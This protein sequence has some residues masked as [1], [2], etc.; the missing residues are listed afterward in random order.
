VTVRDGEAHIR[1]IEQA[2]RRDDIHA[3][4]VGHATSSPTG[5]DDVPTGWA[6]AIVGGRPRRGAVAGFSPRIAAVRFVERLALDPGDAVRLRLGI[7]PLP[8]GTPGAEVTVLARV[9]HVLDA[10]AAS[11]LVAFTLPDVEAGA[12]RDED[13]V[14]YDE[15]VSLVVAD[16]R[17]V[18]EAHQRA[19]S[20][21]LSV[22]GMSLVTDRA[23]P[24]GASVLVRVGLP[25][26]RHPIQLKA[27]VRWCRPG[28]D[29]R[30]PGVTI[31]LVWSAPDADQQHR[32]AAAVVQ[33][34]RDRRHDPR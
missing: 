18:G 23:L 9:L 6:I 8:D 26:D 14:P 34:A 22:G 33:I 16:A 24:P 5:R 32:L 17:V 11:P 29:P 27:E 28:D 30:R 3:V 2:C 21:D 4:T 7:D 19:R 25:G 12:R 31:G 1:T 20:L 15:R 13:R 10:T